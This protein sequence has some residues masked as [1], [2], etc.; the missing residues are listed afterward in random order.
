M[1]KFPEGI[2]FAS[3]DPRDEGEIDLANS[4]HWNEDRSN[5]AN[6]IVPR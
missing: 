2:E 1:K 3:K 5:E 6:N 4:L